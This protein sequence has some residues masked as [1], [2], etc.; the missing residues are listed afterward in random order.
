MYFDHG[1]LRDWWVDV[2][3]KLYFSWNFQWN[4]G[5][6]RSFSCLHHRNFT[7]QQITLIWVTFSKPS[8]P[9]MC[10][11]SFRVGVLS[12]LPLGNPG[13]NCIPR[14]KMMFFSDSTMA[15]MTVFHHHLLE[16]FLEL[17][18]NIKQAHP[19]KLPRGRCFVSFLLLLP[20]CHGFKRRKQKLLHLRAIY[21]KVSRF[22]NKSGW[23]PKWFLQTLVFQT[24]FWCFRY[25]LVVK[26]PRQSPTLLS[27]IAGCFCFKFL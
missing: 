22:F 6:N 3:W 9:G 2:S 15:F 7:Y 11:F 27:L 24:G 21:H 26:I 25:V 14:F 18:P 20:K 19:R 16:S 17:F 8:F 13:E 12:F 10:F 1:V 4:N 23:S 5:T